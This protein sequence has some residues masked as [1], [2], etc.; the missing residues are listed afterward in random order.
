MALSFAREK[1]TMSQIALT[2]KTQR[3]KT[4]LYLAN[5]IVYNTIKILI[6]FIRLNKCE[7]FR[8]DKVTYTNKW[9]G[10]KNHPSTSH[11]V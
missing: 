7:D 4:G 5:K 8:H 9:T 1:V 2:C 6:P 3:E 11:T 10:Y